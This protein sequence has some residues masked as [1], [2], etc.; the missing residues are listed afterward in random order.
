MRGDWEKFPQHGAWL[1]WRRPKK[2]R[3]GGLAW[4]GVLGRFDELL[5]DRVRLNFCFSPEAAG[6]E[7]GSSDYGDSPL[8]TKFLRGAVG[9]YLP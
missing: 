2:R 9:N 4:S 1:G 6:V 8:K 7:F 3:D 5:D